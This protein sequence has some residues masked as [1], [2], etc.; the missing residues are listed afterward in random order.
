[1]FGGRQ[2][3]RWILLALAAVALL[4]PSTTSLTVT[5]ADRPLTAIVA[6]DDDALIGVDIEPIYLPNGNHKDVTLLVVENRIDEPVRVTVQLLDEPKGPP[7]IVR[8]VS[9]ID[10]LQTG[11]RGAITA[12]IACGNAS[13]SVDD[14]RVKITA[15]TDGSVHIL[16]R[17]VKVVCTGEPPAQAADDDGQD[18]GSTDDGADDADENDTST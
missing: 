9:D 11:V 2:G 1:M 15:T 14:V 8:H 17:S 18:D 3:L 5:A 4:A 12:D 16:E 10:S 6:D 7:P 13:D